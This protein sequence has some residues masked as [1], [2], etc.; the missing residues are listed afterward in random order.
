MR[1]LGSSNYTAHAM[2]LIKARWPLIYC[3][4]T[5]CDIHFQS[6]AH[7]KTKI[8]LILLYLWRMCATYEAYIT[9]IL[10]SHIFVVPTQHLLFP[11]SVIQCYTL[12]L[13]SESWYSFHSSSPLVTPLESHLSTLV[14]PLMQTF[15]TRYWME[16]VCLIKVV[17]CHCLY[18]VL[19]PTS[20][21]SSWGASE[22]E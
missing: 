2:R 8:N 6:T 3:R 19:T 17:F 16:G 22:C 21:R 15:S 4:E 13:S 7:G 10:W 14:K 18:I 12:L 11:H 5:G 1:E 20:P 9:G